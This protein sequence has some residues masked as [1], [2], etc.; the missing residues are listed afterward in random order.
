M[1]KSICPKCAHDQFE[2]VESDSVKD[3]KFKI[4]FIQCQQCGTVVGN[5]DFYNIPSLLEKIAQK[6]G[7]S[8]YE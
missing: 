6:L 7:F 2:L 5:T 1:A 4:M 3:S 8:L